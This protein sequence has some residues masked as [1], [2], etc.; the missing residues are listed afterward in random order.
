M[1]MFQ[2]Q[3]QFAQLTL[4]HM[5]RKQPAL[6]A[7]GTAE[8]AGASS[9]SPLSR[10]EGVFPVVNTNTFGSSKASVASFATSFQIHMANETLRAAGNEQATHLGHQHP[11]L[12]GDHSVVRLGGF[13]ELRDVLAARGQLLVFHRWCQHL[14]QPERAC[15]CTWK[16]RYGKRWTRAGSGSTWRSR[17]WA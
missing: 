6:P 1:N 12:G 8:A 17:A 3:K 9:S 13:P 16:R 4:L 11:P 10:W 2:R 7:G 5:H 14:R 15:T